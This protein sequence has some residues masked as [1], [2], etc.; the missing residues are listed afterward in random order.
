[1]T[2]HYD[3]WLRASNT[4]TEF[5]SFEEAKNT[6]KENT[7]PKPNYIPDD[8]DEYHDIANYSGHVSNMLYSGYSHET[9]YFQNGGEKKEHD[10]QL[11]A[12]EFLFFSCFVQHCWK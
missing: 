11:P 8:S 5:R 6:E 9:S 2:R 7:I 10:Y 12:I 3:E 1:M 4:S